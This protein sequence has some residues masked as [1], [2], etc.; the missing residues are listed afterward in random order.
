MLFYFEF[1]RFNIFFWLYQPL[2][3]LTELDGS[4]AVLQAGASVRFRR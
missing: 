3:G 1:V 4:E 2:P